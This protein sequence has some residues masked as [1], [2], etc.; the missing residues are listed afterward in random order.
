MNEPAKVLVADPPWPFQDKLPGRGRGAAKHYGLLALNEL[1]AFP[2]PALAP[3]CMLFLWRVASQVPEACALASAWGF[4]LKTELVWRKQTTGGKRHFGMGRILRAEHEVC[5]VGTRGKPIVKV[6]NVRTIF[7]AHV[8]RHS[9]KP[10]E[11]YSL[12]EGLVDGP[13]AE[14]FARR[15]RA[16]WTCYGNEV[17]G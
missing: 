8:G 16:G 2:L 14:L 11:F 13:Y 5:M 10:D 6:R 4:T 7:D 15:Q 17:E 12:V 9:A 1:K 3:D